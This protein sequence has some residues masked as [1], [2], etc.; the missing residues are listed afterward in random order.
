MVRESCDEGEK[1]YLVSK[2][3]RYFVGENFESSKVSISKWV[4]F[5]DHESLEALCDGP[6]IVVVCNGTA[7][8]EIGGRSYSMRP[9][10]I[11][12]LLD[13]T[14][15]ESFKS[16]KTCSGYVISTSPSHLYSL[17]G[18]IADPVSVSYVIATS[19]VLEV[20]FELSKSLHA[21]VIQLRNTAQLEAGIYRDKMVNSLA[22][23]LF[24]SLTMIVMSNEKKVL[25]SDRKISRG[26]EILKQF[27]YMVG[28]QYGEN[29]SVEYYAKELGISSKYLS[30]ICKRM[31]GRNASKIIDDAVVHK[32][33]TLLSQQGLSIQEIAERLNFV[34]QSFFGKYFKQRVGISPSRFRGANI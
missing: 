6:S 28:Q 23:A 17:S 18:E 21:S 13:D 27:V 22:L 5:K 19:P 14:R 1:R 25:E 8:V 34:S 33:K 3:E 31:A 30:L 24:Y 12:M 10:T 11:L 29:R 4:G 26:E 15:I 16:S 32:A 7:K 9:N 2:V 20:D